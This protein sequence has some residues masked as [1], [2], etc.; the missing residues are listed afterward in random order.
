MS[1]PVKPRSPAGF[2]LV[3][4]VIVLILVGII[5]ALGIGLF[6]SGST[7]SGGAARDQFVSSAMLAQKRALTRVQPGEPVQFELVQTDR[8]W[9]F[10]VSQGATQ[11][12]ERT[13]DREGASLI[14]DGSAFSGS[15][16]FTFDSRGRTG[17]NVALSFDGANAC[18]SSGGFAYL[19]GCQ[20]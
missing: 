9:Q 15:R 4:L 7:Y 16:T 2:T 5:S 20:P 12:E 18:L 1:S 6:A 13:A 11:F 17:E 14:V 3:E 19:G 10:R 8:Q